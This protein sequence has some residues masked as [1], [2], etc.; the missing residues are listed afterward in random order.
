VPRGGPATNF[1][2]ELGNPK[3]AGGHVPMVISIVYS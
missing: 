1:G 2:G 3:L